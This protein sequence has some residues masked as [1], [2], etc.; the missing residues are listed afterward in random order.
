MITLSS[1]EKLHTLPRFR[2]ARQLLQIKANAPRSSLPR[3]NLIV[4]SAM[5]SAAAS[6]PRQHITPKEDTSPS[7][8]E[9]REEWSGDDDEDADGDLNGDEE[10]KPKRQKTAGSRPISVSCEKCKERKV[11]PETLSVARLATNLTSF[12]RSNVTEGSLSVGGASATDSS[13]NTKSVKSLG[14]APG[15][16]AS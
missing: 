6:T 14:Y 4:T 1:S 3:S 11:R 10:R 15:M 2:R 5:A 12:G 9:L 16:V 13:A 8:A 7:N